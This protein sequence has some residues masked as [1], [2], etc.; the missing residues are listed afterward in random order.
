MLQFIWQ[1]LGRCTAQRRTRW[2]GGWPDRLDLR[3]HTIEP[4]LARKAELQW[5]IQL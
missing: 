1:M 4:I 5:A 2:L 3:Q